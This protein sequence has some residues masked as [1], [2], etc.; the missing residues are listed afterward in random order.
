M[1]ISPNYQDTLYSPS[2]VVDL[3]IGFLVPILYGV[4]GKDEAG[5]GDHLLHIDQPASDAFIIV[6]NSAR[7][8]AVDSRHVE[9]KCIRESA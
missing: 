9:R 4:M 8:H 1:D 5:L 6:K 2:N 3:S 7:W